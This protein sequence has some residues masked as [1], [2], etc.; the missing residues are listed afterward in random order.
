MEYAVDNSFMNTKYVSYEDII[1]HKYDIKALELNDTVL[2]NNREILLNDYD[3]P[4]SFT[5]NFFMKN[6]LDI[7]PEYY[8]NNKQEVND[9][10]LEFIKNYQDNSLYIKSTKLINSEVISAIATNN[11]IKE[12]LLGTREDIYKLKEEDY[13]K[14]NNG[15]VTN[16]VTY[17]VEKE[18]DFNFDGIIK[19]NKRKL[20]SY[21]DYE[22]LKI[23][24]DGDNIFI[25]EKLKEDNIKYFSLLKNVEIVFNY[26]DYKNILDSIEELDKIN[27]NFK[28]SI[29]VKDE[30]KE[31]FNKELFNR[32]YISKN[33]NIKY[34]LLNLDISE[35]MR[36][37]K[38]LYKLIEPCM[39]LSDYEKFLYAYNITKHF[40]QYKETNGEDKFESRSL[41]KILDNDEY[42]VCVG[43]SNLFVDLLSKVGIEATT[44]SVGVDI[45]F[46][47]MDAMSEGI[48]G[49]YTTE[50]GAHSRVMVN[51]VDPKYNINGIYQSD[52]TWDNIIDEDSYT[53]SLLTF[54]E[55]TKAKRYLYQDK[56]KNELLYSKTISEFYSN[57]NNYM[58]DLTKDNTWAIK[59]DEES[60]K[61]RVVN[62]ML[63]TIKK[64]DNSF[65]TEIINRYPGINSYD[66][67]KIIKYFNDYLYDIGSYIVSKN[68]NKISLE[69]IR[70][71]ITT[72]YTEF[73][74]LE[75]DGIKK[76]VDRTI[77]FNKERFSKCFPT[78]Y[79]INP[80]DTREVYNY[81]DN[82]FDSNDE[83]INITK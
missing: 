6:V 14:L 19:Y 63:D 45:G 66:N 61:I 69:Q 83:Q 26:N 13:N 75:E 36:Y 39:N 74:G 73:Y 58:D 51:L 40:K 20:I 23:F 48:D 42:M 76:E 33:I 17:G 8:K 57:V 3:H 32:D 27:P 2:I 60:A 43:F 1:S 41:Y 29:N 50:Y 34:D 9:L 53:Y 77:E 38:S 21:Y 16:I 25:Y 28:Y 35:Y 15:R 18:L 55:A 22:D 56:G 72:L 44:Y 5:D 10:I 12:V 49:N 24:K 46:D 64:I 62:D 54:S 31:L 7:N 70:P 68:N 4:T 65:Y 82:K 52:P 67:K 11:N 30:E 80:D 59:M 37:E 81:I 79:K 47:E 71:A 78:T